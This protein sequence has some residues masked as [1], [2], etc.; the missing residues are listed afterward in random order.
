MLILVR[1]TLLLI[2][3]NNVRV[4]AVA[5]AREKPVPPP[6]SVRAEVALPYGERCREAGLDEEAL[7]VVPA[8]FDMLDDFGE[9][10]L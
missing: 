2:V 5:Q 3:L 7:N 1:F 4:R 10:G 6:A 8:A 9:S